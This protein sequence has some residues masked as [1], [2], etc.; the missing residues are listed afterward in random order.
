MCGSRHLTGTDNE[1]RVVDTTVDTL[2]VES[3]P[4]AHVRMSSL[5]QSCSALVWTEL[6]V[7]SFSDLQ[8]LVFFVAGARKVA[9]ESASVFQI[10]KAFTFPPLASFGALSA[11]S[12]DYGTSS[13]R[14]TGERRVAGYT[15]R[16]RRGGWQHKQRWPSPSAQRR[17]KCCCCT[18]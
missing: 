11:H 8:V 16:R 13:H 12:A 14:W 3:Q 2:R 7:R 5:S 1:T 9:R 17:H 18:W 4:A 10:I 15:C 6:R